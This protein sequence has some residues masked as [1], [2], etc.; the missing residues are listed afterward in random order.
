V[1][2]YECCCVYH[3]LQQPKVNDSHAVYRKSNLQ[4]YACK[5]WAGLIKSYYKPRWELFL[6]RTQ[7]AI[8]QGRALDVDAFHEASYQQFSVWQHSETDH[9]D[10]SSDTVGDAVALARSMHAKY[11]PLV[12]V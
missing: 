2:T 10:Y 5:Q 6:N 9:D 3:R 11:S 12:R 4:D 8:A 1:F 7:R